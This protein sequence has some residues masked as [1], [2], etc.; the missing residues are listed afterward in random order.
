M[1]P[2][3]ESLPIQAVQLQMMAVP[4]GYPVDEERSIAS[5]LTLVGAPAS[6]ASTTSTTSTRRTLKPRIAVPTSKQLTDLWWKC[7][8]G[9]CM[10]G[11]LGGLG[12][13]VFLFFKWMKTKSEQG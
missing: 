6:V 9:V 7:V 10:V 12:Y 8:L 13:L 4:N 11:I 1:N 2:P 5:G 3:A